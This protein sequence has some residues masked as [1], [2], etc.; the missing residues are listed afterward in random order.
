M[1]WLYRF[2]Q[3]VLKWMAHH[4]SELG[5]PVLRITAIVEC[6]TCVEILLVG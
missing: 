2:S 4:F 6:R 3:C 5:P 1:G